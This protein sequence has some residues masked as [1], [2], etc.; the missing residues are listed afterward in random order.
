MAMVYLRAKPATLGMSDCRTTP[1]N[2][3]TAKHVCYYYPIL[4]SQQ[5]GESPAYRHEHKQ[6]RAAA[7][8]TATEATLE[9]KFGSKSQA[10]QQRVHPLLG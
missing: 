3:D 6:D 9:S 1:C 4:V 8:L 7:L 2:L 5:H 10:L